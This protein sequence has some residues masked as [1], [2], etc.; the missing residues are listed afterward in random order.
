MSVYVCEWVLYNLADDP[1]ADLDRMRQTVTPTC[2]QLQRMLQSPKCAG[3][4]ECKNQIKI[5]DCFG[6]NK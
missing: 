4:H 6:A 2:L 1:T 5:T 3:A